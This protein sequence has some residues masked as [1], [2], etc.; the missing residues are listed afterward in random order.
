MIRDPEPGVRR[1]T[2]RRWRRRPRAPAVMME[3]TS[4]RMSATTVSP[5]RA[6]TASFFWSL[7]WRCDDGNDIDMQYQCYLNTC[8]PGHVRNHDLWEYREPCDD[9]NTDA[10]DACTSGRFAVR[11]L[12]S[13]PDRAQRLTPEQDLRVSVDGIRSRAMAARLT[14]AF[15][16]RSLPTTP[17]WTKAKR[18]TTATKR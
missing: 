14:A 10:R 12:R 4:R 13:H 17:W 11:L 18:A 16:A 8:A 15:H 1:R 3:T 2:L 9:G 7:R 6:V 5:L